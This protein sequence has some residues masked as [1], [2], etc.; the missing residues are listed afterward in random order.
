MKDPRLLPVDK[1]E[2][3]EEYEDDFLETEDKDLNEMLG[4]SG[5]SGVKK[6]RL[7]IAS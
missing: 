5:K 7:Y 6:S 1:R 3:A 4:F 2:P